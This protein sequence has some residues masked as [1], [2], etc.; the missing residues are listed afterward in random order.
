MGRG[1]R[2]VAGQR[3]AGRASLLLGYSFGKAQ[4]LLAGWMPASGPSS[5]TVPWSR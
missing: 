3:R 4:R 1:Q 2:L 5:C